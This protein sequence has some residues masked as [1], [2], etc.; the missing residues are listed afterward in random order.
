MPVAQFF[1]AKV[2]FFFFIYKKKKNYYTKGVWPYRHAYDVPLM[3]LILY[4]Y[5][6]GFVGLTS[7]VN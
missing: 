3:T 7:S 5:I 6:Y 1:M 4:I 2:P